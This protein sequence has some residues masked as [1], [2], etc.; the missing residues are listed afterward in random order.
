MNLLKLREYHSYTCLFIGKNG[1]GKSSALA[2]FAKEGKVKL[3]DLDRRARGILGSA[4]FLGEEILKKIDVEVPVANNITHDLWKVIV[5]SAEIDLVAASTGRFEYKTIAYESA[6]TLADLMLISSKRMRGL[7]NPDHKGEKMRGIHSFTTPDD[8]NYVSSVYRDF[9]YEYLF[10][11]KCNIIVSAWIVDEWGPNPD[12][13]YLPDM[14][15]GQSLN[16]TRKLAE[17]I[18]GYFDEIYFFSK[19]ETAS[20]KIKYFVQFEGWLAKTAIPELKGLGKI[21]ITDKNF[22]EV[23]Q[24]KM[25]SKR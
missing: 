5:T 11:L 18:P 23:L 6:T 12:S 19:E 16:T 14:R 13:P 22:Y 2:S 21:E 20:G 7:S 9:I 8:Y 17:R 1:C 15:I 10:P 3:I 24:E 4:K 25:T